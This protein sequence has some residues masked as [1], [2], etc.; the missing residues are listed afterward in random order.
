M[1]L[2]TEVPVRG[3]RTISTGVL[4]SHVFASHVT[5]GML[6]SLVMDATQITTVPGLSVS[7]NL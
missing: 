7:Y 3:V 4:H 5:V 2:H 6:G 1:I